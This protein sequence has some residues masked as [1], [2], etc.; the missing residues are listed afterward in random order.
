MEIKEINIPGE[1]VTVDDEILKEECTELLTIREY[2]VFKETTRGETVHSA[3][4]ALNPDDVVEFQFDDDT[5]WI[6]DPGTFDEL[7]PEAAAQVR[8]TEN[9]GFILPTELLREDQQRGGGL[10]K[11]FL[12]V[13]KIF[14]KNKL[15]EIIPT[16]TT[17]KEFIGKKAKDL[18]LKLLTAG[19]GLFR[20]DRNFNFK[21]DPVRDDA[22][23]LLF[24]HGTAASTH[25]SFGALR[26][27]EGSE[28]DA[29]KFIFDTYKDNVLAFEHETLT[30]SPLENVAELVK[31]LPEKATLHLL[32]QS[33]GGLVGDI[34]SR[35][36]IE[37]ATAKGFSTNE[38]NF[39][40]KSGRL[41]DIALIEKIENEIQGKNITIAKYIRVA[42]PANGTTLA[43]KRLDVY[44]NVIFNLIGIALAQVTNPALYFAFK[45]LLAAVIETKDDPEILPGMEIQNPA[46]PFN[47]MLN[48][49]EPEA[50]IAAPLLIISGNNQFGF[51]WQ[52]IKTVLAKLFFLNHN[53]LIVNTESM[54]NGAKRA[55]GHVQYFFDS[56]PDVSHFKYF[57]NEST[58]GA[59]LLAL[60]SDGKT[61]I[62]GFTAL[63]N[64]D[65]TG[66]DIRNIEL[67][68]TKGEVIR[69]K[70]SGKKPIVVL[71][72]GIMGSNLSVNEE[73]IWIDFQRFLQG[74]LTSLKNSD[75]NN[76]HVKATSLV[77]SAYKKIADYLATDYDVVA[78][79]F[80]WRVKMETSAL[81]LNSKLVELLQFNQPIKLIGHSMGG[82]LIRDFVQNHPDTWGKLNNSKDFRLLFLGAPLKGSFRIPAVL[83]GQDSL[84]NTLD[85]IDVHN[86]QSDL[87]Q[88]FSQFSGILSLLPLTTGNGNDFAKTETWKSMRDAFGDTEW[89]LPDQKLLDEFRLYRDNIIKNEENLDFSNAVYIAGQSRKNKETIS[90]YEIETRDTF[91]GPR[92]KLQFLA[93]KEGDESVTWESGIPQ[94]MIDAGTVYYSDVPHGELANDDSLFAAISD[95]LKNGVTSR[96]KKTRPALRAIE[97]EFKSRAAFDFDTSSTGVENNLLGLGTDPGRF[98][99]GEVPIAVTVSNGHLKYAMYP[100]LIGHFENDGILSAEGAV[101]KYLDN[102]LSRRLSLGIYPGPIGSS[103]SIEANKAKKFKGTIIVGLGKQGELNEFQLINT[104]ERGISRYL[105]D[106]NVRSYSKTSEERKRIGISALLVGSGYGGL[107]IED[108]VRAILL[109][110]QIANARIRQ[111]YTVA[112]QTVEALEFIEVYQDRAVACVKAV[113][114]I[115]KEVT[116]TLNISRSSNKINNILGWKERLPIEDTRDWWTRVIVQKVKNEVSQGNQK[117]GL[118]YSVSTDAARVEE[119][120]LPLESEVLFRLLDRSS[121]RDDWSPELARTIFE[122][123]IPH[124]FKEMMKRQNNISWQLDQFTAAFPWELL[125]D[126]DADAR[127][128]SVNAGMIR[129]LSTQDFRKVVNSVTQ[130]QAI[131]IADPILD[132]PG[133][134]L[135]AALEEGKKVTELLSNQRYTVA[136][137]LGTRDDEIILKLFSGDYKIVHL[138]GHGIFNADLSRPSGMMIGPDSYLTPALINQMSGVP[139]LVFV[140]CCYLGQI[141]I[142]TPIASQNPYKLAANIGTQLIE[143]G[144]KVVIVAGWAVNDS[145]A[146]DFAEKFY[147]H[148]FAGSTFGEATRKAREFIY[149]T[150]GSRTNTWGAYQCYG[151]PFYKLTSERDK[152]AQ[153]SF[154]FAIS[155]EAEIELLNMRNQLATGDYDTEEFTGKMGAIATGVKQA[156]ISSARITE[157]QA[158]LY[159]GLG[160]YREANEKFGLLCNEEKATFSFSA[161][162]QYCNTRAK[163][164]LQ[165]V[166]QGRLAKPAA[167]TELL[168]VIEDLKG[169]TRF[170]NTNERLNLLGSTYKRLA[171]ISEG[172]NK[173]KAYEESAAFYRKAFENPE[174]NSRYYPLT[175][176]L[177]IE[178]ALVLAGV[179]NWG[180]SKTEDYKLPKKKEIIEFL[181]KELKPEEE[182]FRDE[183][184]YWD[185]L[186]N[187]NIKLCLLVL[188]DNKTTYDD[189]YE[190]YLEVWTFTG[191]KGN[192]IAEIEHLEF[193]E[194]LY[195]M[196]GEKAKNVLEFVGRLKVGLEGVV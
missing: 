138:A 6:C 111:Q 140:N 185:W 150:Y 145:A 134:Q 42:C 130:S 195:G 68:I 50:I 55:S 124:D 100:L 62:P 156:N 58:R 84:I 162:E 190:A 194:D 75:D 34:L 189:V 57:T 93:T 18:E 193:L 20:V 182:R 71:L 170:G 163:F 166:R 22:T 44:L 128:L 158:L 23:Y 79:P 120:D 81:L 29:W 104:I 146:Q 47:Q 45:D 112:P 67:K 109:G 129:Q 169:L 1:K 147:G 9:L 10:K 38:K 72:P 41:D 80:D 37:N 125:Q 40:R 28:T 48:N 89:P 180:N 26:P 107:G 87:L 184:I 31:L 54:Y 52:A 25:Q 132:S 7:F 49:A 97:K 152:Q 115:E 177:S 21:N 188:G 114:N 153:I 98:K 92:V 110:T 17:A 4:V 12:K 60:K 46:S 118:H 35:F 51:K 186:T 19:T 159:S 105:A 30:K 76:I 103:E 78:F 167:I 165:E 88:V 174:N 8:S 73:Q 168:V 181:K 27:K 65:F 3:T 178:N 5:V 59:L 121:V 90:G 39:L 143:I 135:P 122:L 157:L 175:N 83:F 179:R 63:T 136:S 11:I 96:L 69:D 113:S 95:I 173:Q 53:D 131:V 187:A 86:S 14:S 172:T 176:W 13:L 126:A 66:Q 154:D 149:D 15:G 94:K 196:A 183:M 144:V 108:S 142:K 192:R 74:R 141:D 137:L 64:R 56:N 101:N 106:L 2:Y 77:G 116:N 43:S 123:L 33:R 119:R 85:M 91:F 155:E 24:L 36:C 70:V 16:G 32:S 160:M 139:E 148:M 61:T 82:V 161:S 151:D 117:R 133:N 191:H 171:E 99:A 102:E 164:N 127:P